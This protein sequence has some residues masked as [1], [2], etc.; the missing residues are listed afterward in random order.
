MTTPTH[1]GEDAE[2]RIDE[3]VEKLWRKAGYG[4]D[5]DSVTEAKLALKSL[6]TTQHPP[7]PSSDDG[8][9]VQ[10][11]GSSL[12]V[13]IANVRHMA[14]Q[15]DGYELQKLMDEASSDIMALIAARERKVFG[16]GYGIS[17]DSTEYDPQG[18]FDRWKAQLTQKDKS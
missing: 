3:I 16:A 12:A 14:N 11:L 4:E 18:E 15:H 2:Q 5:Y 17:W 8:E 10:K 9:L 1:N 13:L 6:L 7:T